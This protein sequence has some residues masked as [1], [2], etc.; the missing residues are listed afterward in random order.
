MKKLKSALGRLSVL[1]I[2]ILPT[3]CH[4]KF[5]SPWLFSNGS[6]SAFDTAIGLWIGCVLIFAYANILA[7]EIL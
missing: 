3:A 2:S 5:T 7:K 6:S 1:A 4:Y